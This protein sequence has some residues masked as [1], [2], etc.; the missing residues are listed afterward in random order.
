MENRLV[1]ITPFYNPGEFLEKCVAS[2]MSQRYDNFKVIFVD[3]CSTD[4]SFEKLPKDDERATIIKNET[5]KT[6]LENI[7]FVIMNHCKPEDIICLLDGDDF[8]PNKKVLSHINEFY[9]EHDCW[10]SWGSSIW[11]NDPHGRTCFSSPYT[12]EEF[13]NIRTAPYRISHLRTFRA[14][15]YLNGIKSQDPEFKCLKDTNGKFYT[16]CYDAAI[17]IPLLE[18]SPFLK[19]KHDT[20]KN[21]C[22]VLH[23][24]NDHVVDQ[25]KQTRIHQEVLKKLPFKK[26]ENYL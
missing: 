13:K 12:E 18:L 16:S 5:R 22:Y 11:I 25:G 6:A 9:N 26:I 24:Q 1:I 10:V 8:L 2:L 4:D 15:L 20:A 19:C 7:H 14:G 21:Y 17:F 3:D 23:S